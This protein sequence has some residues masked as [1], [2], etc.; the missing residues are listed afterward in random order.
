MSAGPGGLFPVKTHRRDR[1]ATKEDCSVIS[2]LVG[3]LLGPNPT[4]VS[5]IEEQSTSMVHALLPSFQTK[6]QPQECTQN[7]I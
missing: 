6:K 7:H 1:K 5:Q 2:K 3:T 4:M